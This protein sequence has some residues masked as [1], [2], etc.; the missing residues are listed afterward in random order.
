MDLDD[1][2]RDF[3]LKTNCAYTSVYTHCLKIVKVGKD[4]IVIGMNILRSLEV[5]VLVNL[6]HERQCCRALTI[7]SYQFSKL[8]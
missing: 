3:L 7:N 2:V 8:Q 5:F 6:I 1:R 4:L